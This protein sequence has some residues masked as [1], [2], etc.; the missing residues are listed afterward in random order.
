MQVAGREGFDIDLPDLETAERIYRELAIE[1]LTIH[2]DRD[3]CQNV[4][5]GTAFAEVTGGELIILEGAGHLPVAREP[6]VVNR[7]IHKF[8]DRIKGIPMT[9]HTWTRSMNRQEA[10][11]L[12]VVTDRSRSRPARPRHCAGTAKDPTRFASRL[13]GPAPGH[14]RPDRGG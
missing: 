6:V 12:P 11:P 14:R 4:N 10:G 5:R 2:G 13:A 1:T 7:A 9:S 3:I 8:V